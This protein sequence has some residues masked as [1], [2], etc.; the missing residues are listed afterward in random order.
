MLANLGFPPVEID[1]AINLAPNPA[2]LLGKVFL[3]ESQ[4]AECYCAIAK[5]P[6]AKE[7]QNGVTLIGQ[8]R[9]LTAI[10]AMPP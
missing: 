3:A 1:V 10:S 9:S 8:F 7:C 2:S 6:P 4:A 5:M